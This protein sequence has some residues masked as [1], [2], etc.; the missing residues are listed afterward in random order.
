M[1]VYMCN[2]IKYTYVVRGIQAI[3]CQYIGGKLT[4]SLRNV[5]QMES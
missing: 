5:E 1:D 4:V 3:R 2:K